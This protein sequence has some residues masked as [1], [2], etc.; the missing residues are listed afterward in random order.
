[1]KVFFDH[2]LSFTLA[3]ALQGLFNDE[4][5]VVALIDKFPR[6]ISDADWIRNLSNEGHWIVISGDRRITRNHAERHVIT[7]LPTKVRRIYA[8]RITDFPQ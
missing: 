5:E 7:C 6:D 4:H 8:T 1:M 2:N 3:R